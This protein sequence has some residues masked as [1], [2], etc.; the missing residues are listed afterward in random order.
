VIVA[1]AYGHRPDVLLD[2]IRTRAV[3]NFI[4]KASNEWDRENEGP[5]RLV[6]EAYKRVQQRHRERIARERAENRLLQMRL[7]LAEQTTRVVSD[8]VGEVLGKINTLR[9]LLQGNTEQG[10][11]GNGG[12][13]WQVFDE[14]QK[15]ASSIVTKCRGVLDQCYSSADKFGEYDIGEI[16]GEQLAHLHPCWNGKWDLDNTGVLSCR[17]HTFGG[18]IRMIV[19][20]LLFGA[21]DQTKQ[22]ISDESQPRHCLSAFV[23]RSDDNLTVDVGV[24]ETAEQSFDESALEA[25]E[26]GKPSD[27]SSRVGGLALAQRAAHNIGAHIDVQQS[28]ESGSLVVLHIPV[29]AND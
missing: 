3:D 29:T 12:R 5:R 25:I 27:A 23:R 4:E 9:S 24:Q 1:S 10:A 20:E 2:L 11:Q 6:G 14:L 21:I 7:Y 26:K 16:V 28:A 8:S 18:D 13:L 22:S 19:Q 17:V 15:D